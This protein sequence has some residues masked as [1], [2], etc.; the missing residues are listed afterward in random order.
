MAAIRV[1]RRTVRRFVAGIALVVIVLAVVMWPPAKTPAPPNS[2]S[3]SVLLTPVPGLPPGAIAC[4]MIYLEVRTPYG[5]G[6]R[7]TPS[8]SCGFAEQVRKAFAN[9]A[10]PS[11]TGITQ[12]TVVSP[13]THNQYK[14]ACFPTMDFSTCAGGAGGGAGVVYL[15]NTR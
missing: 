12:L 7:G 5:A 6:A 13:A 3:A 9:A 10:P 4:P 2:W 15:Y 14:L 8:T 1:G 11:S